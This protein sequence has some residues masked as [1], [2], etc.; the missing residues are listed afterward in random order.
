MHG[1]VWGKREL[2]PG[3]R[4]SRQFPMFGVKESKISSQCFVL[5]ENFITVLEVQNMQNTG[6][7]F[8]I[9]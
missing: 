1:W 7:E 8:S 9:L 6:L 2:G 5:L 3:C 4:H